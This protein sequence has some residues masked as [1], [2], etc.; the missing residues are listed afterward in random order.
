MFFVTRFNPQLDMNTYHRR[1]KLFGCQTCN[2]QNCRG[3]TC[4]DRTFGSQDCCGQ[5][6]GGHTSV[7]A[8]RYFNQLKIR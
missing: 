8:L 2:G 6:C 7:S 3:H 5:T 4:S 1:V